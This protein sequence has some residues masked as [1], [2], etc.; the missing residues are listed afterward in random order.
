MHTIVRTLV[1][2]V[3]IKLELYSACARARRNVRA[4][5]SCMHCSGPAITLGPASDATYGRMQPALRMRICKQ[6]E[7]WSKA[8]LC[9]VNQ[10]Y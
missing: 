9:G 2:Y 3:V 6:D 4:S 10:Y 5:F 1:R 8:G 7:F